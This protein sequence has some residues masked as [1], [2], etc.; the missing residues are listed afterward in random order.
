MTRARSA[1]ADLS[2]LGTF[3]SYLLQGNA[4]VFEEEKAIVSDGNLYL[5]DQI[6]ND[7]RIVRVEK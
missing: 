1:S 4:I 2:V 3:P 7:R 5:T 6:I